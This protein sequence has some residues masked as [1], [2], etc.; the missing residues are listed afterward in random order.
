MAKK[1]KY[2]VVW[3]GRRTGVFSTW[4]E[5]AAQVNGFPGAEFKS[6]ET[7][8]EAEEAARGR[9]EEYRGRPAAASQERLLE[10]GPPLL[11]SY[12]VD[13]ACSGPPGPVE[14]RGVHTRT[15]QLLFQQGPFANGT[16]NIGEFL[17][18]VHALALC[19][20]QGLA[21][22]VY[23]DSE[24]A[25]LWVKQKRCNTRLARDGS[26]EEL[27]ALIERAERW[28]Q[29]NEYANPVLKWETEAWGQI[30][31]DYGRK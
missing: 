31:A 30:P 12:A 11:E 10:V 19:R 14:Y 6:F 17:A 20:R 7:R 15:G 23:S 21:L 22:P 5:C 25:I 8:A 13:A 26:N 18:I 24:N 9:Y 1:Q 27:F 4:D 28:L 3:K 16:N 2:Y 29:E